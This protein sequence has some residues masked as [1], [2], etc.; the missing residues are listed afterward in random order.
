MCGR[1]TLHARLNR[2]LQ[3]FAV[4]AREGDIAPLFD[5]KPRYNIAATQQVPIFRQVDGQREVNTLGWRLLP[6]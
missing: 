5:Y 4:A 6:I 3:Q 2:L 1:Y